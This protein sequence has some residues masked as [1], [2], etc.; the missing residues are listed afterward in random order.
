MATCPTC[1]QPATT[2]DGF[3]RRGRQRFACHPC[4]R[5]FTHASN[6]AFSGYRWPVPFKKWSRASQ[7]ALRKYS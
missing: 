5:D 1:H 4:H 3:D 7:A 6:G 2:R